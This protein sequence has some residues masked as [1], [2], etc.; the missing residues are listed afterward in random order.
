M[1]MLVGSQRDAVHGHVPAWVTTDFF[2]IEAKAPT[3][4]Q[5]KDQMRLMIQSLLAHRFKLAVHFEIRDVP[6]LALV[7]V[8]PGKLGPRLRPHSEGPACDAKIPPVDRNSQ[9]FK[10]FNSLR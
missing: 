1:L 10:R 8:E 4:N 9:Q 7:Q 6:V 3:A 2:T 5:T